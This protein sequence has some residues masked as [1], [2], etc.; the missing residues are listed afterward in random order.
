MNKLTQLFQKLIPAKYVAR[1]CVAWERA[2]QEKGDFVSTTVK[3]KDAGN[4]N[5][6][7]P[8]P[9]IPSHCQSVPSSFEQSKPKIVNKP[10]FLDSLRKKNQVRPSFDIPAAPPP[11]HIH[12][13]KA[14]SRHACIS[15]ATSLKQLEDIPEE[16]FVVEPDGL[17]K[18]LS[19]SSPPQKIAPQ[20][21]EIAPQR[22]TVLDELKN[23]FKRRTKSHD[24]HLAI[25]SFRE[26]TNPFDEP[27]SLAKEITTVKS[28]NPFLTREETV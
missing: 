20:L 4:L 6:R 28:T 16:P 10:H 15:I 11:P 19:K 26:S 22:L 27:D 3:Y 17:E 18:A 23:M 8:P 21:K 9:E 14:D 13:V 25:P 2:R 5:T 1:H 7:R 24:A 12:S